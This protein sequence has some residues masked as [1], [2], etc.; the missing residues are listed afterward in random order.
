MRAPSCKNQH[1]PGQ[2]RVF[3]GGKEHQVWA[4]SEIWSGDTRSAPTGI[5]LPL[6]E[7]D[8]RLQLELKML[9]WLTHL[10]GLLSQLTPPLHPGRK[11]G[12]WAIS[13]W[14]TVNLGKLLASAVG[15]RGEARRR[16]R[17]KCPR[18]PWSRW[19]VTTCCPASKLTFPGVQ[20]NDVGQQ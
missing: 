15:W 5:H 13:L 16:T 8:P 17:A 11:V 2:N 3:L 20:G 14:G 18:K 12:T 4:Q 19:P 1:F 6:W 9:P 10:C 7:R